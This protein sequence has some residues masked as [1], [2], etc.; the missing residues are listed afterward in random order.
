MVYISREQ[1]NRMCGTVV[2][3]ISCM[4]LY[5]MDTRLVKLCP[6][7]APGRPIRLNH[8]PDMPLR[9]SMFFIS[10]IMPVAYLCDWLNEE[11]QC[12][13]LQLCASHYG[14][15]FWCHDS[16]SQIWELQLWDWPFWVEKKQNGE[17]TECSISWC[18][19]RA[20]V[21][22]RQLK[23]ICCCCWPPAMFCPQQS[24]WP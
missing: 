10:E 12:S 16:P 22:S 2:F 14:G 13:V 24:R 19:L 6:H 17:H 21:V 20:C 18:L 4:A 3:L 1:F 23:E 15:T 5:E 8:I 7:M 9:S 11:L